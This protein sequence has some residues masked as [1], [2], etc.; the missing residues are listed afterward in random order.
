VA[1]IAV[2]SGAER[3]AGRVPQIVS[4]DLRLDPGGMAVGACAALLDGALRS[5]ARRIERW[6]DAGSDKTPVSRGSVPETG[7]RKPLT[8]RDIARILVVELECAAS[9]EVLDGA[10]RRCQAVRRVVPVAV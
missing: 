8:T 7:A 5:F 2:N 1:D 4:A 9:I 6:H 3:V 10:V